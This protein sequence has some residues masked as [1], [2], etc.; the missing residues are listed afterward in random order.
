[1]PTHGYEP[2]REAAMVVF[3][4]SGGGSYSSLRGQ[5]SYWREQFITGN[6]AG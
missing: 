3:A 5:P 2:T 6:G 4:K 1:M